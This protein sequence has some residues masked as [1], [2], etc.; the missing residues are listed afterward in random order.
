MAES[1]WD[2]LIQDGRTSFVPRS[3]KTRAF[4]TKYNSRI[5]GSQ[6]AQREMVTILP[7]TDEEIAT[8][9]VQIEAPAIK[10]VSGGFVVPNTEL[11]ALKQRM[12]EQDEIIK[13]LLEDRQ[14]SKPGPKPKDKTDGESN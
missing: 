12:A 2:K 14:R 10:P 9:N 3:V 11:E 6:N 5:A 1:K 7:A 8:L 4:W 13:Q